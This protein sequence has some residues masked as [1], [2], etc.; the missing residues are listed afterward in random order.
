MGITN[1]SVPWKKWTNQHNMLWLEAVWGAFNAVFSTHQS[2]NPS[3]HLLT[4]FLCLPL[5]WHWAVWWDALS[6]G[7][8]PGRPWSGRSSHSAGTGR[9]ACRPQTYLSRSA[10]G[11]TGSPWGWWSGPNSPEGRRG[12]RKRDVTLNTGV[13]KTSHGCPQR[14]RLGK[15]KQSTLSLPTSE[16]DRLVN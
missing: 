14:Q 12:E 2:H 1:K 4:L 5:W 16:D 10:S 7:D 9:Q 3:P 13:V 11:G 15:N 8:S 6:G